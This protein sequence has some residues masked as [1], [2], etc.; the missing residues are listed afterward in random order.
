MTACAS[1]GAQVYATEATCPACGRSTR[2]GKPEKGPPASHPQDDSQHPPPGSEP[3]NGERQGVQLP[4]TAT[5]IGDLLGKE[6]TEKLGKGC[7]IGCA[8]LIALAVVIGL[9]GTMRHE[10]PVGGGTQPGGTTQTRPPLIAGNAYIIRAQNGSIM[11]TK[12]WGTTKE[13]FDAHLVCGLYPGD[14]VRILQS[15]V[16]SLEVQIVE[17]QARAG[18][19]GWA[20]REAFTGA[21]LVQ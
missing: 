7:N 6:T 9:I 14:K 17:P 21:E 20:I 4:P 15:G 3:P 13:A 12:H 2:E 8:V 16:F 19:R 11:D 10:S 18:L 1:C 5:T